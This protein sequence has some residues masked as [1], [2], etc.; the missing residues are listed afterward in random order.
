ML[1]SYHNLG[2]IATLY[3]RTVYTLL[4]VRY[5]FGARCCVF[6][7]R[8]GM[9]DA[10]YQA[11]LLGTFPAIRACVRVRVRLARFLLR[12]RAPASLMGGDRIPAAP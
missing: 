9:L 8:S 3:I 1:Y 11:W 12:V 5:T 7:T 4:H 10:V 6:A 2:G